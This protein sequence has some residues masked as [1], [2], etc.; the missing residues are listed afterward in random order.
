MREVRRVLE[1]LSPTGLDH[2]H[3]ATAIRETAE[4]LGFDGESGPSFAC[5][6]EE[7]LRL[8]HEVEHMLNE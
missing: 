7:M 5:L 8:P 4:R 3:L 2:C 1:V 6:S